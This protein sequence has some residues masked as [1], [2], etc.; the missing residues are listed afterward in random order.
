MQGDEWKENR[1]LLTPLFHYAALKN[2]I[3]ILHQVG[4][5][6]INQLDQAATGKIQMPSSFIRVWTMK[7]IICFAFGEMFDHEWMSATFRKLFDLYPL[8]S[9]FNIFFGQTV[10][11]LIPFSPE[12]KRLQIKASILKKV[13]EAIAAKEKLIQ[14][15]E[16]EAQG[17][18]KE[19]LT[20]I[21]T[22]MLQHNRS[23]SDILDQCLVF[24]FGG[25]DTTSNLL[26]MIYI[27][28]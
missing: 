10:S 18:K 24:L 2:Q 21:M 4:S 26:V 22:W 8:W 5:E 1:H 28:H 14:K 27:F 11:K 15:E 23:L 7:V 9:I 17:D 25:F 13:E 6:M 20:D 12:K 19:S 3:N 16:E